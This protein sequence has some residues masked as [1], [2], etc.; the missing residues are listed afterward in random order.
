MMAVG[1]CS[2]VWAVAV[3]ARWQRTDEAEVP[4]GCGV[5]GVSHHTSGTQSN[6]E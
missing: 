1:S 3:P 2:E 6:A 5:R 4:C